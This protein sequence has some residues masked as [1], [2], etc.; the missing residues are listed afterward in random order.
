M[1]DRS[2]DAEVKSGFQNTTKAQQKNKPTKFNKAKLST[3]SHR[4]SFEQGM[5]S[6][7]AQREEKESSTLDEEWAALPQVV[8]NTAKIYLGK[9]DRTNQG[10][11]DPSNQELQTLMS[12]G[13]QAH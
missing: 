10:L 1:L 3:I 11:F 13:D 7:L 4:D 2:P 12:R 8:Y 6:V 9:P 5:D